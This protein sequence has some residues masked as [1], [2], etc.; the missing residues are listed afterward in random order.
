V[1][2]LAPGEYYAAA[3]EEID[4]SVAQYPEF[5]ARFAND[6]A[7][8]K[9]SEGADETVSLKLIPTEQVGRELAKLP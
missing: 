3:W 8:V 1:T 6:A 9:L 2:G 4:P 7:A 5:L